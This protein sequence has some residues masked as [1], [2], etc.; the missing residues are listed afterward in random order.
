[1][2]AGKFSLGACNVSRLVSAKTSSQHLLAG[3][4]SMGSSPSTFQSKV[5]FYSSKPDSK[6]GS[7]SSSNKGSGN[8]GNNN[9]GSSDKDESSGRIKFV[10][11]KYGVSFFL[12][13]GT[14][15]SDLYTVP[16]FS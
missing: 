16:P 9:K 14:L 6:N 12:Y 10:F 3:F 11:P 2:F 15:S 8:K 1:M 13:N 5:R 4:R 7:N